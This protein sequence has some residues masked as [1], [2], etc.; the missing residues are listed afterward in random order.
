MS[1]AVV[2]GLAALTLA[3]HPSW[4]PDRVKFA[5]T[6]T[7]HPVASNDP[8]AVGA[9]EVDAYAAAF[10]APAGV[11]NVGLGRSS[12]LGSLDASRGTTN[13]V[14]QD[15]AQTLASGLLTAQLLLWDPALFLLPWSPLTWYASPAHLARWYGSNWQGSNWQGS[16]WQ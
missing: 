15:P 11:A 6:S 13:V 14:F 9:G 8:M 12:G 5:L 2:S 4:S 7:A 10:T 16:N 1:T 3:A